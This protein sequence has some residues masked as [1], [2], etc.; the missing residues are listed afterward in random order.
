M[1]HWSFWGR[2]E[3]LAPVWNQTFVKSNPGFVWEKLREIKNYPSK[4]SW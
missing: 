2:E 1:G 4:N 3:S